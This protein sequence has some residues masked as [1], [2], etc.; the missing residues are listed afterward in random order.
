MILACEI[1]ASLVTVGQLEPATA[2]TIALDIVDE[3]HRQTHR[4]RGRP[5]RGWAEIDASG[6]AASKS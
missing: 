6:S 5:N 2:M 4:R 3:Y 1:A